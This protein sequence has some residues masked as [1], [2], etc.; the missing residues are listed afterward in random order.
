MALKF[1]KI[2][3]VEGE[4]L[5]NQ[6]RSFPCILWVNGKKMAQELDFGPELR[7]AIPWWAPQPRWQGRSRS[8]SRRILRGRCSDWTPLRR[9][10]LRIWGFWGYFFG[11]GW[12][13]FLVFGWFSLVFQLYLSGKMSD[14]GSSFSRTA[15]RDSF[16]SEMEKQPRQRHSNFRTWTNNIYDVLVGILF[17][18][19]EDVTWKT[20]YMMLWFFLGN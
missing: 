9:E 3:R 8:R 19:L 10:L 11:G 2:H 16:V 20:T 4:C 17:G 7:A 6:H 18:R 14:R 12:W 13:Y 1:Y 15:T 5:G